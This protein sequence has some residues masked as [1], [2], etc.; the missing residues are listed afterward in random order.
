MC[1]VTRSH[2]VSVLKTKD[3]FFDLDEGSSCSELSEYN[4]DCR[5]LSLENGKKK[6]TY[7]FY[8]GLLYQTRARQ[9]LGTPHSP[10]DSRKHSDLSLG[11]FLCVLLALATLIRPVDVRGQRTGA[12]ITAYSPGTLCSEARSLLKIFGTVYL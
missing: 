3:S 9:S 5:I 1:K 4:T 7:I 6:R 12:Q 10:V 2:R 11:N 8:L